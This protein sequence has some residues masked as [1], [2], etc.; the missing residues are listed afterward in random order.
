RPQVFP[1]LGWDNLRN[2]EASQVVHYTF[3]HCKLT[4]DGRYLIPDN[5]FT[6][7]L[8]TSQVVKFAELIDEWKNTSSLT[9]L[10]IIYYINLLTTSDEPG[11][12]VRRANRRV[13]EHI[14]PNCIIYYMYEVKLTP[15]SRL[16]PEFKSRLMEI[17]A[18]IE[19]DHVDMATYNAQILVRDFG[20]HYLT[21]VTAGAA[22]VKDDFI[23]RDYIATHESD[24]TKILAS[25][26]ASFAGLFSL[27]GSYQQQRSSAVDAAY[28]SSLTYSY[29]QA[30]GGPKVFSDDFSADD[31]AK[32]VNTNLVPMDRSGD[33][34][35]YL[36]TAQTLPELPENLVV[37]VAAYVHR[38][39]DTYYETN[40]IL[41]CTRQDSP[42]FSPYA[43]SDD[44]S[45]TAPP[46]TTSY[47]GLFQ[48]CTVSGQYLN[49]NPCNGL[50]QVNPKTGGNT[51]PPTF[52]EVK[53]HQGRNPMALTS[54]TS[55]P[56]PSRCP[57]GFSQ[58]LATIV[59]GCSIYYCLES[60]ALYGPTIPD[61]SRPPFMPKPVLP[62]DDD[63]NVKD[64]VVVFNM[65]TQTWMKD[66]D[67]ILFLNT[68]EQPEKTVEASTAW[69]KYE[70]IRYDKTA[71]WEHL[72]PAANPNAAYIAGALTT[73]VTKLMGL[74]SRAV[75]TDSKACVVKKA[76][77]VMSWS[78]CAGTDTTTW[79]QDSLKRDS[80]SGRRASEATTSVPVPTCCTRLQNLE[81]GT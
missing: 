74:V 73:R 59:S 29:V 79:V 36:I 57:E 25:A 8:K 13:E 20:T 76:T 54:G 16:S 44:G 2:I 65:D 26:S 45:C 21:S 78:Y 38:A 66:L 31:W 14:Q 70:K 69:Y 9:V 6:V 5:V 27:G 19:L 48:T 39:I 62:M 24:K 77:N 40:V 55:R 34:L 1:G 46:T 22:L 3:N 63:P 51:C 81:G 43:N 61:V 47:G 68:T 56:W 18:R 12:E 75:T 28:A 7:P 58:H 67:A 60:G 53:L 49:R 37:E 71:L 4:N 32:E 52:V 30:L 64:D 15:D 17:A 23:K 80:N 50:S 35:Y 11:C 72:V 10:Y 33:P 42:Q 41:G